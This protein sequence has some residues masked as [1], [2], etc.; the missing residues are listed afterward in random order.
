MEAEAIS[1]QPETK[2]HFLDYWRIIRIRKMVILTVFLLVVI[3]T[4]AVTYV[5]P[6]TYMSSVR[7]DVQKDVSD[8]QFSGMSESKAYD[9]FFVLTQFEKLQ[10]TAVIYPVITDLGLREKWAQR[11]GSP[12]PLLDTEAYGVLTKRL[13]CVRSATPA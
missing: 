8:V 2:L 12:V 10:S 13:T 11:Y 1:S 7:I 6:K 4:T 9:P 3:T 5:L